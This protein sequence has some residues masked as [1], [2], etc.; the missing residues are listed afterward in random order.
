MSEQLI[1]SHDELKDAFFYIRKQS[2]KLNT[3]FM[4]RGNIRRDA[5]TCNDQGKIILD[6]RVEQITFENMGGGVYRAYIKHYS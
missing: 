1:R 2:T 5:L 6:G 4:V 3:G